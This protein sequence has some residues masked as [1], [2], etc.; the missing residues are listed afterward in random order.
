MATKANH[1]APRRKSKREKKQKLAVYIM[2][3]AMLLSSITAGL[4]YFI[5]L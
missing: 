3:I 1:S 2:I 4:A 5:N